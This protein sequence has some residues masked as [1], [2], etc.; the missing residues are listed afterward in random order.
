[1]AYFPPLDK[2]LAGCERLVSWRT[3]YRALCDVQ[4]AK[5]DDALERFLTDEEAI[6]AV[7]DEAHWS[8]KPTQ[9]TKNAF[10]TKVAPINVSQS[11]NGDYN[12]EEIKK[13]ALWL[14]KEVGV[15]ELVA[16]RIAVLEWQ[17]RSTDQLLATAGSLAAS[18]IDFTKESVRQERLLRVYLEE[19]LSMLKLR[20]ELVGH[21]GVRN[22]IGGWIDGMVAKVAN[23][24]STTGTIT[25]CVDQVEANML[26]L[27]SNANWPNVFKEREELYGTAILGALAERL[28]LL[29][30]ILHDQAD[31]PFID[32]KAVLK[33]FTMM[34]S[35][36]F[37]QDLQGPGPVVGII[38]CLTAIVS[39]AVLQLPKAMAKLRQMTVAASGVR[40]PDLDATSYLSQDE[41]LKELT[42]IF[43][44]VA[45]T[46]NALV[47]PALY[48]WSI[49]AKTY[50]DAAYEQQQLQI[51]DGS[52]DAEASPDA[53]R[54]SRPQEN[55]IERKWALFNNVQFVDEARQDP[56]RFFAEEA[57]DGLNVYG[58]IPRLSNAVTVAYGTG[59]TYP[60]AYIARSGL[61]DLMG[62]GLFMLEYQSLLLEALL[63]VINPG[64]T[65][66]QQ[67]SPYNTLAQSFLDPDSA[68]RT[69]VLDQA[70][71]RYPYELS[72]LLKL[73]T[74]L[75]A[76]DSRN[77]AGPIEIVQLLEDMQSL[78]LM[79]PEH[80]RAYELENEEENA[81]ATQL[82]STLP[83]FGSK[84][85]SFY[86]QP[87]LITDREMKDSEREGASNVLAVQAGTSGLIV[88]EQRPMVFNLSHP[89]SALEYLGL[90]LSTFRPSSDLGPA[91]PNAPLDYFTAA[92]LISLVTALL[93]GTLKQHQGIKE[94][95]FVLGRLNFAL[96]E[97]IDVVNIIA[98]IFEMELL[99]HTDQA[100]QPGSLE[101]CVACADFFGVL[102]LCLPERVWGALAQ[103]SLVGLNTG[104][105]CALASVVSGT[106]VQ[107]GQYTF[108][109]AC[110]KLYAALVEDGVAGLVRRKA[111]EVGR[112]N[113]RF[114][115]PMATA[116]TTPER[117]MSKV[118]E[119]YTRVM[120]EVGQNLGTWRF[121]A[122]EEKQVVASSVAKAFQQLLHLAY[123][124]EPPK[125]V[126]KKAVGSVTLPR[127][128][129]AAL[130]ITSAEMVLDAFAP[131]AVGSDM[132]LTAVKA[133]LLEG[134]AASDASIPLQIRSAVVDQVQS[135]SRLLSTIMR[136]ARHIDPQR[137]FSLATERG[138]HIPVIAMLYACE[139]S[140]R[141]E[142]VE[143]LTE[144][145]TSLSCTEVDPPALLS[146]L[147]TEAAKSFLA[148][149]SQLDRPLQET[150]VTVKIWDL[151]S[152]VVVSKQKA[153]ALWVLTGRV[154]KPGRSTGNDDAKGKGKTLLN[155]ALTELSNIRDLSPRIAG[156]MLR[157]VAVAQD[158][159][160]WATEDVRN[161]PDFVK[162][163]LEWLEGLKVPP[164]TAETAEANLSAREF[165]MAA[166]FC[167]ILSVNLH[168]SLEVGGVDKAVLQKLLP[169]L[170]FLTTE[171]VR[172]DTYNMSLHRSLA[173]NLARKY[174]DIELL[175]F[176]RSEAN[177]GTYGSSFIYDFEVAD[178]V[179]SHQ[180][181]AWR[182]NEDEISKGSSS[183]GYAAE[184]R[185][186][187]ANLS[188]VDSQTR[189]LRAWK[190][191]ATTLSECVKQDAAVPGILIKTSETALKANAAANTE[192]PGTAEVLLLRAELVFVVLNRLVQTRAKEEGMRRL[193]P[194][195]WE[196]VVRSPVNFDVASAQEDLAYYRLLLQVLYLA[197]QPHVYMPLQPPTATGPT[198]ANDKPKALLDVGTAG[199]VVD[200]VKRA[201][202]PAF[203]ALA[204]N[205]HTESTAPAESIADFGLVTALLDSMLAVQG[206]SLFH[207]QIA[208]VVLE[209][210]SMDVVHAALSMY[211]WADVLAERTDDEPVHGELAMKFLVKLSTV[212]AIAE[213]MAVNGILTQL[214]NANLSGYFRKPGGR[215]PFDTPGL[216]FEIWSSGYLPLC[217]NLLLAVGPALA[218]EVVRFLNSFPEQL[219]RAEDA[220]QSSSRNPMSGTVTL[221]LLRETHSLILIS[222]IVSSSIALAAA[223]GVD[224]TEIQEL[225]Y[226]V[227][228]IKEEVQKLA[229]MQRSLADKI[230]P[231][232]AVARR[233]AWAREKVPGPED[234]KLQALVFRELKEVEE[235]CGG[236]NGS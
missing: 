108:L 134:L 133:T 175:D 215:G 195:A 147:S 17:E 14:S 154:G 73:C 90:L 40:Y 51:E 141:A 212:P 205:L 69:H 41:T 198:A 93:S 52:S 100:A 216:A 31:G 67:E 155:Q 232:P 145:V 146:N 221:G 92:E 156:A 68:F 91:Y 42:L 120:L 53:R 179:L 1:M 208:Q 107:T 182:G 159:W 18:A 161:H 103:S 25:A 194:P 112:R 227:Q 228:A 201:I 163:M 64:P 13:D 121:S 200:I 56:A 140:W 109:L 131:E 96:P 114:D 81:N 38:Q 196:L 190:R 85:N 203:R 202:S 236:E 11:S 230:A 63:V 65:Q 125:A 26:E 144:V 158:F 167:D 80:F 189:L 4:E 15:S 234:N 44:K 126:A 138:K 132:L 210:G 23:K 233:W 235:L 43:Y 148:I 70:F 123:G 152:A 2:C 223:E 127:E 46:G 106:E 104:G 170:N 88:R 76:V 7:L 20:V 30:A 75:A 177:P 97:E 58:L 3:A 111:R 122:L 32:G 209:S 47:S 19:K 130:L 57:V 39:L 136:T 143:L 168:A 28:R 220:Y 181:L 137:A 222:K 16:L 79:V 176:K 66:P 118:L 224:G 149:L 54:D 226:D 180:E 5:D 105:V 89:H 50:R 49:I 197:L 9:T 61:L 219:I 124:L 6:A 169:K 95:K 22:Q 45:Q 21:S 150:Q 48:A 94:A 172:V 199:T 37:M 116:D 214:A 129:M 101:L 178:R 33:W 153:L 74:V 102:V 29:L 160:I 119:T 55:D 173:A 193:L 191:L 231:S 71:L 188:L 151:L 213:R 204:A 225:K 86:G 174:S 115:S 142:L 162:N 77:R 139:K 186:A 8:T 187:N 157:F 99:A 184:V 62:E 34:E 72:P 36:G 12:L 211:S 87:L 207:Q 83:I 164:R 35:Y 135:T 84:Q 27:S 24:S 59:F 113:N 165:S 192:V 218:G 166:S 60:S 10:D 128:R 117:T 98:E 185:R 78:T 217:L 206:I 229:R 110:A 82:T 183:L 171:A